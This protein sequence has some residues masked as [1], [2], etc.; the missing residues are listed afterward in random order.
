MYLNYYHCYYSLTLTPFLFSPWKETKVHLQLHKLSSSLLPLL[1]LEFF[2]STCINVRPV[3][4]AVQVVPGSDHVR[5]V[6]L[7]PQDPEGGV[8]QRRAEDRRLVLNVSADKHGKRL[9]LP[10]SLFPNSLNLTI[11]CSQMFRKAQG[12]QKWWEDTRRSESE[13]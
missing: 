11:S 7:H 5:V 6:W 13:R 10:P 12:W 2:Y 8:A 1:L 9:K 4:F 3:T